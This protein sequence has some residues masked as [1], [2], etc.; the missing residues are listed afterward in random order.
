MSQEAQSYFTKLSESIPA[1]DW[2]QWETEMSHAESRQLLDPTVMDLLGMRE[3]GNGHKSNP[4][5]DPETPTCVEKWIQK[6]IDMEERQSVA[7]P[8]NMSPG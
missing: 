6:A 2:Q 7:L 1:Q 5:H 3:A 4:A 8:L